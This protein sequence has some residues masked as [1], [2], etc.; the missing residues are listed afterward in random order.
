MKQEFPSTPDE[1]F[2]QSIEG[3][4]YANQFAQIY[5]DKRIGKMP[6]NDAP[7][8][9]AWDLGVGGLDCNMVLARNQ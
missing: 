4:Y 8:N 9:T 6:A 7:V 3:A 1:A 5:A 2:E